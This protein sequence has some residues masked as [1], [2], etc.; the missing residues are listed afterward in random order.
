MTSSGGLS[1]SP[2]EPLD[3]RQ[4]EDVKGPPAGPPVVLQLRLIVPYAIA[5]L[6]QSIIGNASFEPPHATEP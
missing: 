6:I 5:K 1:S 4:H 2:S 3:A